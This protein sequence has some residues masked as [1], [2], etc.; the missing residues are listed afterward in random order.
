MARLPRAFY[1]RPAVDVA[2]ELVGMVLARRSTDG[3]LRGRI[4]ETEAYTGQSD[5][6]SHAFRGQTPRNAV[7]FGPAGFLYVYL[8]Y[9]MHFCMNIVTDSPGVAGAV[10]IRALEPL[11]GIDVME[12]RRGGRPLV[13]LCNGPGKLCAAL[14]IT[15]QENGA[16]LE[17]SDI[18]V[19][20]DS[21]PPPPLSVSTRIG[22]SAGTEL[23]LR[24]YARDSR[25]V[26]R[27]RP[28]SPPKS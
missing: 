4:V 26:S 24:F 2:P 17:T 9:G 28:P 20:S 18:W 8:S 22:L 5:P 15:R 10:L 1:E 14:G 27:A 13:E 21:C 3:V 12:R 7:M 6:G 19:E 11:D 23:P 16:D 25:F